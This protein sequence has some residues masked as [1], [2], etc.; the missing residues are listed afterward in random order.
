MIVPLSY[1]I[2]KPFQSWTR[3]SSSLIG[4]VLLHVDF[5]APVDRLRTKLTEIVKASK[6]WDGQVVAL[7]VTEA[8][9][10]SIEL[11]ALASARTAADT[12]DLRCEIREKL[13]DFLQR[14]FPTA[15][16]HARAESITRAEPRAVDSK[17]AESSPAH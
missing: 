11:R 12:F 17:Q 1:F 13:I 4:S 16:P 7:Q 2:E 9:E 14:E 10:N 5:T 6:L 3:E 15:L 8:K